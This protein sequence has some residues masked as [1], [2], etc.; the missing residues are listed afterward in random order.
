DRYS[1][2]LGSRRGNYPMD[3]AW[4]EACL[5][6]PNAGCLASCLPVALARSCGRESACNETLQG[7]PPMF[8]RSQ[9]HR[10]Q[11]W[12]QPFPMY[13]LLVSP[14]GFALMDGPHK[15]PGSPSLPGP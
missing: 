2:L 7:S 9:W 10:V 14:F 6:V 3:L 8:S 12:D 13:F 1:G 5:G 4:V 15:M 11:L